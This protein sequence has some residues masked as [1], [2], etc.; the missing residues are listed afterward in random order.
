MTN[1]ELRAL[2]IDCLTLWD[3]LRAFRADPAAGWDTDLQ[4]GNVDY[5]ILRFIDRA[6]DIH[7]LGDDVRQMLKRSIDPLATD[8]PRDALDKKPASPKHEAA[9]IRA[10]IAPH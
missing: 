9:D 7:G 8:E 10:A 3:V 6:V 5:G 1:A 2:L 4:V